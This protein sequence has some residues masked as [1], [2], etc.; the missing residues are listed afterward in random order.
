MWNKNVTQALVSVLLV[1]GLVA[2]T[3]IAC[4][5][6]ELADERMLLIGGLIATVGASASYLFRLNGSNHSQ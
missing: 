5:T 2:V 3:V 4:L 6:P 1:V